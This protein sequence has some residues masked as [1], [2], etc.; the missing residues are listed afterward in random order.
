MVLRLL[1]L[2]PTFLVLLGVVPAR[3]DDTPPPPQSAVQSKGEED[4]SPLERRIAMEKEVVCRVNGHAITRGDVDTEQGKLL[5]W[6]SYHGSIDET[7]RAAL[8][9][10]AV[11]KAIDRELK[12]QDAQRRGIRVKKRELRKLV[13]KVIAKYPD[14]QS[15]EETLAKAGLTRRDVEQELRRRTMIERVEAKVVDREREVSEEEARKYYEEHLERFKV[16]RQAVVRELIIRVP[17]LGRNKEVW[18]KATEKAEE[19]FAR[20]ESGESFA[21][22]VR[23]MSDVDEKEKEA[24]GLLGP[25]HKGRFTD[26]VD[27]VLWS[28]PEGGVSKPIKTLRGL[29]LFKVDRF[30]PPHQVP[31][32]EVKETLRKDLQRTWSKE[33]EKRWMERLRKE[34]KIEYLKPELAPVEGEVGPA[35]Q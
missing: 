35:V 28:L 1:F 24:G 12:Y 23:E 13:A 2:S 11:Q 17:I 18:A 26:A 8:R 4:L 16:P 21:A 34:A 3:A 32:E 22:L 27:K 19:A 33:R 14:E 20:I 31:F 25:V 15:F 7:K 29:Y 30:I 9:R 10:Q 6:T 5:P